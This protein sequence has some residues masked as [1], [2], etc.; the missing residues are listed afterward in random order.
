LRRRIGRARPLGIVSDFGG[1]LGQDDMQEPK[2]DGGGR[3]HRESPVD[4]LWAFRRND[5]VA[6]AQVAMAEPVAGRQAIDQREDNDFG[7]GGNDG[8]TKDVE[9]R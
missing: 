8:G 6:G 7:S 9:N 5:H 3:T 2:V 1:E 4:K